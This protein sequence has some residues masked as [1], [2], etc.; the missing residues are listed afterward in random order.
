MLEPQE[1]FSLMGERGGRGGAE[2]PPS[3][4]TPAAAVV[5]EE[6]G[7]VADE[8]TADFVATAAGDCSA[9]LLLERGRLFG[10]AGWWLGLLA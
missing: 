8:D 1:S 4:S 6:G 9:L 5:V 10:C 3:D 7:V 2:D